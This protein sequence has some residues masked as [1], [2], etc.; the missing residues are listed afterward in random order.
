MKGEH[1]NFSSGNKMSS[2][3]ISMHCVPCTLG[4][5]YRIFSSQKNS[6]I[7]QHHHCFKDEETG[8]DKLTCSR[9]QNQ[10]SIPGPVSVT[11]RSRFF[12]SIQ[13]PGLMK[14][15]SPCQKLG[16]KL[17]RLCMLLS[18]QNPSWVGSMYVSAFLKY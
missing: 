10:D 6:M 1:E 2:H 3:S 17:G 18:V 5:L 15:P 16:Q 13:L 4:V 7:Y 9:W 8:S 14:T 12:Q 11:P